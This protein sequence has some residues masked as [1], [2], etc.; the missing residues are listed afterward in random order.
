MSAHLSSKAVNPCLCIIYFTVDILGGIFTCHGFDGFPI[1]EWAA[2]GDLGV[3]FRMSH[4][5]LGVLWWC[6]SHCPRLTWSP[7]SLAR[8]GGGGTFED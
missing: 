5:P 7:P 1:E 4:F 8:A 3:C 2:V 6:L